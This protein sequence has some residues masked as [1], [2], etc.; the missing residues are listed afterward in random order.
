MPPKPNQ[1]TLIRR[2]D[3]RI[4]A[5]EGEMAGVKASLSS[6]EQGQA[7]LIAMFEKSLGKR[8]EGGVIV[9]EETPETGSGPGSKPHTEASK[10]GPSNDEALLEFRQAVKKV[11]LPMFDGDDPAGWISRAEVYFRVQGTRPEVKVCLA[12]LCM[13]GATIHFFN[14]LINDEE[15]LTWEQLKEALLERYGGHGDGDI[16]EQLTELRQKGSVD[17]YI[18]EFEYL[19][20]QI[21]RLPEKQ[22]QGYFLHGLKEEIKGKVRSMSVMGNLSRAKLLQVARAVERETTR[23]GSSSSRSNKLGYG[24]NRF[25]SS[26]PNKGGISDW[27]L[28]K[29][30]KEATPRTNGPVPR[31]EKPGQ[32]ER[33]NGPRDRGFTHLS[34]SEIMERRRKNQ[35]FKCAGPFSSTHQCPDKNLRLLIT[36]DGGGEESELLA[37]EVEEGD[38]EVEGEMSLM[39]FH[40]LSQTQ[41]AKPQSIKLKGTIHEVPVVILIDSGATHN[42]I[43]QQ[44]AQKMNLVTTN[45][46]P[47]NIRL[48]DGSL[49]RTMGVCENL[50]VD[51]EGLQIRVD[52]QLFE[53]GGM[54]VVLGIEWLRTLG[55]MII[56]WKQHTMSFWFEKRWVTLQ[57]VDGNMKGMETLLSV[58][59]KPK[60]SQEVWG[61]E[62]GIKVDGVYLHALEVEQSRKLEHLLNLCA[63]VFQEPKGLPP[64]RKK[65]HVITLKEGEGPVN[66]RPYRYPHHHKNEI[67][68]QVKEMLEMGVIRP[69]TSSFSSPVILVKKKDGSWRMCIDYRALNKATVPDKFP[70]PVIEELLD[71][72]HGAKFFSKLDLKSGYHQVRV[73]EEDIHKTAFRTHEGHYEFMV[74]PFG[75]MNA[76]STFQSLMNEVFRPWLRKFVLVFFDD[77]LVYSGDWPTHLQHLEEVLKLLQQHGLVAN[78]R[79]CLF[80]QSTVEY[81]GHL[82]LEKE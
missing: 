33:R 14:S 11:E 51:L 52:V 32:T 13:E 69:S 58:I 35:C 77:I 62:V 73:K 23:D 28:V 30:S 42:F 43:S 39:S 9:D 19:T 16:Y 2:M 20:A 82:I 80:G 61:R 18:T 22:F 72:L 49:S 79:K 71:E 75:L 48:G 47:L 5:L 10:T 76:P 38:E 63:D 40:Q 55:D 59:S 1:I 78:K 6:L 57:G 67:E 25:G 81:L 46:S 68:R 66:V 26:G 64:K 15:E 54:D 27:V 24:S 60:R 44:L 56:N 4:A 50:E 41:Q 37:V 70:I 31:G 3:E 34:Y 29:G 21:P 36:E 8:K 12:H 45:T 7:T 74:M 65:E 17:D 53:L